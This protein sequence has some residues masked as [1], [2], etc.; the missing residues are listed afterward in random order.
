[1]S[2]QGKRQRAYDLYGGTDGSGLSETPR[3]GSLLLIEHRKQADTCGPPR[4]HVTTPKLAG[5]WIARV[6][7]RRRQLDQLSGDRL[8]GLPDGV[9]HANRNQPGGVVC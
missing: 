2:Y 4:T 8:A 9:Q 3:M 1:M 5:Q 7:A 6:A